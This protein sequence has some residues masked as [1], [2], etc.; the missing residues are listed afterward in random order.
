MVI[1]WPINL[2]VSCKLHLYSLQKTRSPLGPRLLRRIR[3]THPL[4]YYNLKGKDKD[5]HFSFLIWG[6]ILWIELSW[7]EKNEDDCFTDDT[8]ENQMFCIILVIG[9]ASWQLQMLLTT[10]W[11]W[12]TTLNCAKFARY[13]FSA[14]VWL[15]AWLWHPCLYAYDLAWSSRFL[16]AG[17]NFWIV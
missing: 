15:G 2:N 4:N 1:A 12:W 16:Q 13:P 7:P 6:I 11:K 8:R 3:N 9:V 14:L 10:L 5:V 17:W